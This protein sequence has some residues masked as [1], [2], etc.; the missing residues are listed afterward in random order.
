MIAV[1]VSL[2]FIFFLSQVIAFG[3][4]QKRI[5]SWT[6]S[7]TAL[8]DKKA[9]NCVLAIGLINS[10]FMTPPKAYAG[11]DAFE[12]AQRVNSKKYFEIDADE[13]SFKELPQGAKKRR[14]IECCKDKEALKKAR[15][16][17][18]TGKCFCLWEK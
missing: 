5:Q 8:H 3:I 13:R 16:S 6:S 7:A 2:V 11:I 15:Y 14:A 1:R 18:A 17:S 9:V 12:A 10:V 4:N